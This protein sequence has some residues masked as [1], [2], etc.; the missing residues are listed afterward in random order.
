LRESD[1][2]HNRQRGSARSQMQ[3]SSS[4]GKFHHVASLEILKREPDLF[5]LDIRGLD[6]RPPPLNF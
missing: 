6:D 3:K 5:S 1:P 2:R 4:V